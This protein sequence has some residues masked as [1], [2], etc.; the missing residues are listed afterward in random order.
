MSGANRLEKFEILK[1]NRQDIH[2]ADYN[3]RK[4]SAEAAKKLRKELGD[5]GLLAPIVVNRNSMTVVSGHQRLDAMDSL[6]RK[7]DYELHVAMVELDEKAEIRA[8]VLLN[9]PAVQ[10]EWD[11]FKL[12]SLKDLGDFNFETDFGFDQSDISVMFGFE[13]TPAMATDREAGE[14][15]TAD[16]FR[17]IKKQA[18]AK[19]KDDNAESG[20]YHLDENDYSITIV[21]PNNHDKRAFLKRI[22]KPEKETHLKSPVLFDIAAGKFSL[23]GPTGEDS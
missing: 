16:H 12:E 6:L 23:T 14:E 9:N 4:I 5:I 20:S 3:P 15:L 13:E 7:G 19:A 21:F 1:V 8:N 18:R 2:G 11:Q 22:G 17:D 10:G